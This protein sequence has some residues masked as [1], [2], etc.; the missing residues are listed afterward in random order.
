MHAE[1]RVGHKATLEQFYDVNCRDVTGWPA[2]PRRH[3][4]GLSAVK[5]SPS[6][7]V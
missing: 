7:L 5:E 2:T 4:A 1:A 6:A 3:V